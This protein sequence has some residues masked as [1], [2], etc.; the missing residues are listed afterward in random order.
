VGVMYR[1]KLAA[2]LPRREATRER[3]GL[4]MAGGS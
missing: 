4:L 3:L 1:G 2:V